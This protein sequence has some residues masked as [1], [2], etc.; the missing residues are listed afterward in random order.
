MTTL[1]YETTCRSP[2]FERDG[3]DLAKQVQAAAAAGFEAV[4]V[5]VWTMGAEVGCGRRLGALRESLDR[6]GVRCA[7]MPAIR[8]SPATTASASAE[9]ALPYI[10]EFG[11]SVVVTVVENPVTDAVVE[12]L[13]GAAG[14]LQREGARM[15]LEFLPYGPL[16]DMMVAADL[17]ADVGGG[18]GICL[19]SWHFFHLPAGPPWEALG[20]LAPDAIAYVQFDDA[21]RAPVEDLAMETRTQRKIPGQGI[22]DLDRFA[23]AVRSTGYDGDV[24]LEVLTSDHHGEDPDS[25]AQ[26]LLAASLHYWA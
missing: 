2:R 25:F 15:A 5:D 1:V 7:A 10:T 13:R 9:K 3:P 18:A 22:L 17:A 6:A 16:A 4:T 19:D 26:R 23:A 21:G 14:R 20:R 11:P 8:T 12:D 24:G